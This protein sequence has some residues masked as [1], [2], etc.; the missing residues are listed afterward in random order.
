M[1]YLFVGFLI[2]ERNAFQG[3]AFAARLND[4]LQ[5]VI[6]NCECGEPKKIHLEQAHF[7]D[8][9]HVKGGDDF[10]VLGLVQRYELDQWPRGNHDAC[11]MNPSVANEAFQFLG[12]VN[13][14]AD[15]CVALIGLLHRRRILNGLLQLYI[16]RRWHHFGDAVYIAIRHIHGSA[17][18][19]DRSARGHG[20]EGDDLGDVL[21]SV[22][23]G[24]VIDHFAAAVHAEIDVN[25]R[26]GNALRIQKALEEQLMLERI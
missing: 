5:R 23:P 14:F 11:R 7:L 24:D 17:H 18:V 1:K 3:N 4:Q 2:L 6:E 22:L 26:H 21:A 10:I 16:Q 19:F 9:N 15:L 20:A 12:G 25:I 13:Q 8:G